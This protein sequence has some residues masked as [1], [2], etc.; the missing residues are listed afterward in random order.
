MHLSGFDLFLWAAGFAAHL[1]LFG[2]LWARRRIREFPLFTAFI[3][4][5]IVRTVALFFI[6]RYGAKAVY[7]Y[8]YWC[9]AV[10]DAGLQLG[11]VY[12]L[13]S[14]IFRPLGEWA[15]DVQQSLLLLVGGGLA[16]AG[17]LT[18]LATP[19]THLWIQT[20][21]I[22]ANF[23]TAA[24]MSELFVGMLA[25][26]VGAGRP[27]KAHPARIAQGLGFYSIVDVIIETAHT[28]FG[29]AKDAR[30]YTTLSHLRMS[31]YLM[32]VV[33]WILKLW[34]EAP[35]TKK[36]TEGMREQLETLLRKI[37]YGR[38]EVHFFSRR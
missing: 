24:L 14:T 20:W 26:S 15:K 21:M 4:L 12:E 28:Y 37:E 34:A 5:N 11:V 36:L 17:A 2:V 35:S 16:V 13:C 23:F 1:S 8:A 33:F 27:W 9:L 3:L 29:V 22:K 30:T 32:C 38:Q 31:V 10:V 18:W 19:P 7:F 25:I 6:A